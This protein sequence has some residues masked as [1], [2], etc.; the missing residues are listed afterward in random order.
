MHRIDWVRSFAHR[1]FRGTA[2]YF[3]PGESAIA[4][5][6]PLAA[7]EVLVGVYENES[8]VTND[9]I[10]ITDRGLHLLRHEVGDFIAYDQIA[11]CVIQAKENEHPFVAP[12][13]DLRLKWGDLIRLP[14]KG[15][16]GEAGQFSDVYA[17]EKFL[18]CIV[19]LRLRSNFEA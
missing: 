16:T 1:N 12:Y 10:G 18:G 3:K 2:S 11:N 17:I 8:G 6:F 14:I 9:A 4:A 19:W 15:H 13:V 5:S 7:D